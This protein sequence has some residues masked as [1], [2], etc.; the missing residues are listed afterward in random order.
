MS[1]V[2]ILSV[3][4]ATLRLA[5][6]LILAALGGLFSERAG[7]VALGL[8][9]MMLA[10]AFAAGSVAAFCTSPWPAL[11]AA[12]LAAGLVALLHGFAT[13]TERG[14]QVVSGMALNILIGGLAPSLALAWFGFGGQTP[15]LTAGQRFMPLFGGQTLLVYL[16]LALLPAAWWLLYRSRFGL[17]LRAVGENPHAVES[18]GLSVTRLRYLALLICGALAGIAGAD[19]A[20]AEGAGFTRDMTAGRGYLA[21]AALIFGKWRPAPTVAACLI[22]AGADAIQ[23]RLQGVALPGIG[24]IP[25]QFVEALPYLATLILLAG[26]IGRARAPAALG[27]PFQRSDN[28]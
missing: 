7:I 19:L 11:G 21:L 20:I 15:A 23:V 2:D 22:F 18:A 6:P 12:M 13:I 17:R 9:G 27:T 24:A 8:E 25:V 4:A 16:T 1:L 14:D 5:T 28:G 26:F 10:G 3:L